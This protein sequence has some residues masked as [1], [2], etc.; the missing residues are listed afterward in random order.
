MPTA[1]LKR[2]VA[3]LKALLACTVAATPTPLLARLRADGSRIFPESGLG[4]ADPWQRDLLRRRPRRTFMC[5]SR[6][7]GK[8][9]TAAAAALLCA[10]TEA[11]ALVLLVAPSLRQSAELQRKV[12]DLWNGLGRPVPT[13]QPRDNA[14]RLELANGSRVVSLPGTSDTTRGFSA[15]KLVILEECARIPDPVIFSLSPVLAVS[16]GRLIAL[17]TPA[18]RRG[19][20]FQEW[21][22]G[23][24]WERVEVTA[25][26]V[27]RIPREWLE[28]ERRT[29]GDRWFEQEY[30]CCWQDTVGSLF[31]AEDVEAACDDAVLPLFAAPTT[32]AAAGNGVGEAAALFGG[33][34]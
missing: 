25:D 10:L 30:M 29:I 34:G 16:R 18:G 22:H 32:P 21:Q 27:P 4:E 6:Q 8:S 31:R 17:T 24:G 33:G 23:E 11:P 3:S 5:C 28:S 26:Q 7:S 14:L 9:T 2:E 1:A 15:A 19:W 20:A 12:A 13:V